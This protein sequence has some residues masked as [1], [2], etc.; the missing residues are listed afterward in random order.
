MCVV[1][2]ETSPLR[3]IIAAIVA[4]RAATRHCERIIE[5][6][7]VLFFP[8]V[9]LYVKVPSLLGQTASLVSRGKSATDFLDQ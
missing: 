6:Y 1:K 8:L 7:S 5:I 3:A 9:A 4:P 2:L